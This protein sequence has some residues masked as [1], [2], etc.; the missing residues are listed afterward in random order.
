MR[1]T[2]A[3]SSASQSLLLSGVLEN[4]LVRSFLWGKSPRVWWQHCWVSL[5]RTR[6]GRSAGTCPEPSPGLGLPERGPP[7]PALQNSPKMSSNMFWPCALKQEG[8]AYGLGR[9]EDAVWAPLIFLVQ[10]RVEDGVQVFIIHSFKSF[11][12]FLAV[13]ISNWYFFHEKTR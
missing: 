10:M 9:W 7:R 3:N 12:A 2:C 4:L 11:L 6:S 1:C 8:I 13:C 5:E